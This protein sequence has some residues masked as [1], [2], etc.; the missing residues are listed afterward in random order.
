MT[1]A[2]DSESDYDWWFDEFC[3]I[4]VPPAAKNVYLSKM[5]FSDSLSFIFFKF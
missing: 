4:V 3:F 1:R 2:T 5:R